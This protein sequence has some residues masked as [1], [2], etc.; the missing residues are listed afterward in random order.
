MKAYSAF[1][2]LE[3]VLVPHSYMPYNRP[4][5]GAMN[6]SGTFQRH[7]FE[8]SASQVHKLRYFKFVESLCTSSCTAAVVLEPTWYRQLWCNDVVTLLFVVYT[9]VQSSQTGEIWGTGSAN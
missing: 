4:N 7:F 3:A 8:N 2:S 1:P 6:L 9:T 5:L